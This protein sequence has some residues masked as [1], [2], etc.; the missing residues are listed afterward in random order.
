MKK[1]LIMMLAALPFLFVSCSKD[2]SKSN[3]TTTDTNDPV[4]PGGGADDEDTI[5]FFMCA[6]QAKA[7]N[8]KDTLTAFTEIKNLGFYEEERHVSS[9]VFRKDIGNCKYTINLPFDGDI[10]RSVTINMECFGAVYSQSAIV[11]SVILYAGQMKRALANQGYR[12]GIGNYM[13]TDP[14]PDNVGQDISDYQHF[15]TYEAFINAI[16]A[17]GSHSSLDCTASAYGNNGIGT[18]VHGHYDNDPGYQELHISYM[19]Q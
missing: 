4:N 5:T 2:E 19:K 6:A 12:F 15:D 14:D 9:L 10:V 13:W 3:D 11:D 18:E 16:A 8:G 7:W 1:T 17:L